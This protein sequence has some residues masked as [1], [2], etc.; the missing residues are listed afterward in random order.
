MPHA[1][2]REHVHQLTC[3]PDP[4]NSAAGAD[5]VVLMAACSRNVLTVDVGRRGVTFTTI[6]PVGS[7]VLETCRGELRQDSYGHDAVDE[8][9]APQ[10]NGP[11]SRRGTQL[12]HRSACRSESAAGI[13]LTRL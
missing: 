12:C 7:G 8:L 9:G 5:H 6:M 13:S 3:R 1:S 11:P 10:T 2:E 4:V